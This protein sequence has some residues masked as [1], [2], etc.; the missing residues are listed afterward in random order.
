MVLYSQRLARFSS[1]H[2]RSREIAN[3]DDAARMAAW[4]DS[5]FSLRYFHR[6]ARS[7]I[8]GDHSPAATLRNRPSQ[9]PQTV[10]GSLHRSPLTSVGATGDADT[11]SCGFRKR[12]TSL[13]I[14]GD[15]TNRS[16]Y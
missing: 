16:S 7:E 2:E 11:V 3:L 15:L 1:T 4:R 9:W 5:K 13:L 10:H 8:E 6:A 12:G 14:G